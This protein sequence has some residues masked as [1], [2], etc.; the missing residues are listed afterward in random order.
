MG[1]FA[2]CAGFQ[3]V[4]GSLM[5]P[6]IGAWTADLQL[7]TSNAVTGPVSVVIGNLTLQGYV[8]RSEPYGGQTRARLVGGYGGW[9]TTI[10]DQGYG[11]SSGVLLSHIL[12]DAA[13]A[14]GERI[15]L[16]K[17]ATVGNAFVRVEGPASDVLWQCMSQGLIS[18]WYVAPSG[19]TTMAA[20]PVAQV[21]TPFTVTDQQPDTG[22]VEIAT[23]DYVS[24]LPG[25][26]F[27]APQ[28]TGSYQNGG[29]VYTFDN[30]GKFRFQVLTGTTDRL[31][32]PLRAF[33]A[34]EVAPVRFFGRYAYSISNPTTTTIDG[35]PID[36]TLGLPQ[37]QNVP[38]AADSISVYTPPSGGTAHIQFVDGQPTQPVCVWTQ[39]NPSH[40]GLLAGTTP[41]AKLGD[42]VQS[43]VTGGIQILL[44]NIVC[45][46]LT[47]GQV[48]IPILPGSVLTS[49]QGMNPIS[50]TITTGSSLLSVPGT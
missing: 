30:E 17:D 6:M 12:G 36:D 25:C 50:G 42:T 2:S 10:P 22:L 18:S 37:L 45:A 3:V 34:S 15:S 48:S 21:Q 11:S 44:G 46:P 41:A 27:T 47:I 13:N 23:E 39:G 33:I 5:V 24:W 35:S 38:I 20:W 32:G 28:L 14:C 16:P 8:Y 4:G 49:V 19:V 29:V 31:L 7:A 26:T 1:F 40:A 43:Y 9:R